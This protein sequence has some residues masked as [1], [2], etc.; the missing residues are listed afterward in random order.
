MRRT[1][2][3]FVAYL[4]LLAGC[5]RA[6]RNTAHDLVVITTLPG[7]EQ[8]IDDRGTFSSLFC[9]ILDRTGQA[10]ENECADYLWQ[11]KPERA[12]TTTHFETPDW[13]KLH[14]LI[15]PGAFGECVA[16]FASPF[17]LELGKLSG[18]TFDIVATEGRSGTLRN[19]A[20]I[21]EYFA[22]HSFAP[23]RKMAVVAYSKGVSDMLQALVD[24]PDIA[25]RM[26]ALIS[27]SGSIIGS[28]I[29]DKMEDTYASWVGSKTI[30]GCDPGD[31]KVVS[32]LTRGERIAFLIQNPLPS[33]V[34]YYS[35]GSYANRKNISTALK[36]SHRFLSR[37]D[38][39]NDGQLLM[40]D[41]VIPG[42]TLLG[43]VNAD[44]WAVTLDLAEL[45]G[46][47]GLVS[48]RNEYPRG[49]LLEAMLTY[50]MQ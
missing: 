50:V 11:L 4:I 37:I 27:V 34:D 24:E 48:N 19:A 14:I 9:S 16:E 31:G 23:E 49:V 6:T 45:P 25:N 41:V 26:H 29:A 1:I 44:H 20:L 8:V 12:P 18:L 5:S 17:H 15:I 35:V 28:P 39:R 43:F 13:S 10:G 21:R 40:T 7:A 42:S 3:V 32:A 2:L 36:S 46:L 33:S 30:A 47:A 22:A 38:P